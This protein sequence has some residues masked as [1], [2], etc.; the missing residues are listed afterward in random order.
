MEVDKE[1]NKMILERVTFHL[2]EAM[3]LYSK[4]DLHASSPLFW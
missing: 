4:L 3:R 2:V 1:G